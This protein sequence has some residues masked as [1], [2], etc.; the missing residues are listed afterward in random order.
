MKDRIVGLMYDV[1]DDYLFETVCE[2]T[3]ARITN[4]VIKAVRKAY[5]LPRCI[6][7]T[8]MYYAETAEFDVHLYIRHVFGKKYTKYGFIVT[9]VENGSSKIESLK[10]ENDCIGTRV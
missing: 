9:K 2:N 5:W 7:I 1:L 6:T 10:E 4:D 8:Y 3:T